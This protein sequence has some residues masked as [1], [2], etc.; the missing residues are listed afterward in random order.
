MNVLKIISIILLTSPGLWVAVNVPAQEQPAASL[1]PQRDT[2]LEVTEGVIRKIDKEN[3]K[4]TIRHGEI[5]NLDMPPM[6]MVFKVKDPAML[7]T[8]K[9]GDNVQFRAEKSA[10]SF[11]ITDILLTK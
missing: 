7:D 8:V 2:S 10:G 1:L 5:K 3:R 9:A 4:I 11:V 6:T